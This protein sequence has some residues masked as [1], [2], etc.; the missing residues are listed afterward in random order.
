METLDKDDQ[1]LYTPFYIKVYK[2]SAQ[3]NWELSFNSEGDPATVTLTFD[4]LENA[5]GKM[6]DLIELSGDAQ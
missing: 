1:G 6:I 5:D 2:A 3:R 4:V